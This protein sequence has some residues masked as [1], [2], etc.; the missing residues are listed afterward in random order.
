M[1]NI[2]WIEP[3]NAAIRRAGELSSAIIITGRTPI[4]I[5]K[6]VAA[7]IRV[8]DGKPLFVAAIGRRNVRPSLAAIDR[9]PHIVE[10]RLQ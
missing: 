6:A 8:V 7:A 1:R 9:A 4:L 3:A 10:E 5:L 2:D